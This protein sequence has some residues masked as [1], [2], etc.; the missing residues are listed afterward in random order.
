MGS[1]Q[2]YKPLHSKINQKQNEK[3]IYRMGENISKQCDRQG[4]NLQNIQ[5]AHVAQYQKANNPVKTWVEDIS[6]DG[7]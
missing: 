4:I 3:T 7:L 1:N 6:K 2:T 5:T